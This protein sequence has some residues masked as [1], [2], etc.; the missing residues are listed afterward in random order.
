MKQPKS[1]RVVP[2]VAKDFQMNPLSRTLF[3]IF[4]GN[5]R[6]TS[7]DGEGATKVDPK[8]YF[9][10]ERTFLKWMT[11]S[12]YVAGFSI[13]LSTIGGTSPGGMELLSSLFFLALA[14]VIVC[15]SMFQCK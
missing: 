3:A 12:I 10:N 2:R 9:A 4:G 5:K 8:L 13:G 14:I 7:F 1:D 11:V 6:E 15:Y